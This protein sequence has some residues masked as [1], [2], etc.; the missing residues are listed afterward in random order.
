MNK[1]HEIDKIFNKIFFN[2]GYAW[3]SSGYNFIAYD[4]YSKDIKK[5]QQKIYEIAKMVNF[6][7]CP[8]L[9]IYEHKI[10]VNFYF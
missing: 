1:M 4:V 2:V 8:E 9:S 10:L 3:H 6:Y 7:C 5:V